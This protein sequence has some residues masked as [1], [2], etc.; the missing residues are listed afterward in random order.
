L[1]KKITTVAVVTMVMTV[2]KV[3]IT[4]ITV[5]ITRNSF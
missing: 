2:I 5:S 3:D 4:I 1:L